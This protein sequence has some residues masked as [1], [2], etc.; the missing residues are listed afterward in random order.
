MDETAGWAATQRLRQWERAQLQLL[1]GQRLL[2]VGCGLGDAALA[3][4]HDLGAT[5]ALVGVDASAEMIA[6]ARQRASGT[7]SAVRFDVSDA[8]ALAA[9][10]DAFD[11]VRSERLLQWV[12]EPERAVAE[13]ARVVRA[14]GLV[15]LI[16]TDW[17]TFELQV[18]D[19]DLART[20][21][22]ALRLERHRPSNIGRR[23]SDL[24]EAAGLQP[25]AHTTATETWTEWDPDREPAPA[26][27]FSMSSLADDL[28]ERGHLTAA[29]RDAFVSTVHDAARRG[30]FSMS[31]TMFAVVASSPEPPRRTGR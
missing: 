18:G 31:L 9:P 7:T 27:C 14:G 30:Q 1:P 20:V 17:S 8:V 16:D 29:A 3:L 5:G 25:S 11:A 19:D 10:D 15:S 24:A 2:D 12:P 28:V 21:R 4:A 23:L 6:G 13:M 26:G 22:E